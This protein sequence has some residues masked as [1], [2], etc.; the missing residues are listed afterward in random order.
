VKVISSLTNGEQD[1][2]EMSSKKKETRAT[3]TNRRG[4]QNVNCLEAPLQTLTGMEKEMEKETVPHA[5]DIVRVQR[6]V[7]SHNAKQLPVAHHQERTDC[8]I[9]IGLQQTAAVRNTITD[10]IGIQQTSVLASVDDL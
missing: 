9:G 5:D 8:E 10:N 3:T 2:I 4:K 7:G 1:L 6:N